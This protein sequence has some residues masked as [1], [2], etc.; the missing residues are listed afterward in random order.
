MDIADRI[1]SIGTPNAVGKRLHE[2]LGSP[3]KPS[4]SS[5]GTYVLKLSKGD[6]AWWLRTG[7]DAGSARAAL[8]SLLETDEVELFPEMLSGQG[9]SF[10]E[11]RSLT[12]LNLDAEP[13]QDVGQLAFAAKLR[14][15][16]HLA[17][18]VGV[19][20]FIAR[21]GEQTSPTWLNVPAGAG[22]TLA[23]KVAEHA[24]RRVRAFRHLSQAVGDLSSGLVDVVRI[25]L[26]E[27]GVDAEALARITR[28]VGVVVLAPFGLPEVQHPKS[29]D[30]KVIA[31]SAADWQP[32][33]AWRRTFIA[34]AFARAPLKSDVAASVAA[35]LDDVDSDASAVGT[36]AAILWTCAR[37]Y[38]IGLAKCRQEG[39]FG[40]M[41]AYIDSL[42]E[43][44]RDDRPE[45]SQWIRERASRVV[46]ALL[47]ARAVDLSLRGWQIAP[48]A[49]WSELVPAPLAVPVDIAAELQVLVHESSRTGRE[50]LARALGASFRNQTSVDVVGDLRAARLLVNVGQDQW[51]L[52]PAWYVQAWI[53]RWLRQTA[54]TGDLGWGRLCFDA[55]RRE[56]IDRVLDGAVLEPVVFLGLLARTSVARLDVDGVGAV[57]AVFAAVGRA[58]ANGWRSTVPEADLHRLWLQ[59][60]RCAVGRFSDPHPP[61][62]A[63]RRG[64]SDVWRDWPQ[65]FETCWSWSFHVASPSAPVPHGF[66]LL[67]PGWCDVTVADL[68]RHL[69]LRAHEGGRLFQYLV[70]MCSARPEVTPAADASFEVWTAWVLARILDGCDVSAARDRDV[71]WDLLALAVASDPGNEDAVRSPAWLALVRA[72]LQIMDKQTLGAQL[73]LRNQRTPLGSVFVEVVDDNIC[74]E[75]LQAAQI[76]PRSL[77]DWALAILPQRVHLA[78]VK[79]AVREDP[80]AARIL[81]GPLD[82]AV[83]VMCPVALRW[84]ALECADDWWP[85]LRDWAKRD[86]EGALDWLIDSRCSSKSAAEAMGALDR[87]QQ[88]RFLAWLEQLPESERPENA[89]WWPSYVIET[90]PDLAERLLPMLQRAVL[91]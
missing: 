57:E 71:N 43:M 31:W 87:P 88:N 69:S 54:N 63:S 45:L 39:L 40:L 50:Q 84:L 11:W 2:E 80:E 28:A 75:A 9:I 36:P 15:P 42:A 21:S 60:L 91:D 73:F 68:P 66:R 55:Q 64:S 6:R 65:W 58:L 4:A 56:L 7:S 86:P 77:F 70:A 38:D 37:I 41:P 24:G 26:P 22:K 27:P 3:K 13:T 61:G 49:K 14:I 53:E 51:A 23:L 19:L 89:K 34:W 25:E 79:W 10:A 47:A 35:W 30:S 18:Q 33:I 82:Q 81:T 72:S 59:Q 32:S 74:V 48:L 67:F 29:A 5:F 20:E 78:A 52:A 90:R 76:S 83:D 12:P 46:D 16:A 8:A 44:F 17:R 85:I 62:P 1:R